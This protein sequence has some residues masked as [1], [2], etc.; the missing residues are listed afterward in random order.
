MV[1]AYTKGLINTHED[2][3]VFELDPF[4]QLRRFLI[5]GSLNGSFYA[6]P[7]D[8]TKLNLTRVQ[9]ALTL[10]GK[11]AIDMIADVSDKGLAQSNDPALA[12]LAL[13]LTHDDVNVRRYAVQ[14]FDKIVR[15]GTHM[16]HFLTFVQA[17]KK[18]W[19]STLRQA[20]SNW[21]TGKADMALVNQITKYQQR[22]GWSQADA[23]R[24]A[25]PKPKNSTQEAILGYAIDK[26]RDLTLASAEVQDYLSGIKMMQETESI[27][28]IISLIGQY[29][30]P[31]EVLPTWAL[32]DPRVWEA[33]LPHMG[34]QAMMR[35]LG[36]MASNGFL[37]KG[38]QAEKDIVAAIEDTQK[39]RKSRVHPLDVLKAKYVYE[40]G[41]GVRGSKTWTATPQ[42]V[43]ALD[44]AF[45][46]SFDNVTPTGKRGMIALDVSASMTW[47]NIGNVPN[48]TPR[49]ASA[50]MALVTVRTEQDTTVTAFS[51]GITELPWFHQKATLDSVIYKLDRIPP[52]GTDCGLPMRYAKNNYR[53][54][55]YFIVYTDSDTYGKPKND[56]DNYR[57][58]QVSDARFICVGMVSNNFTLSDP[59][60]PLSMDVVGF[61]SSAPAIMSEFIR[62]GI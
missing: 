44:D 12:A 51:S 3:T 36:V 17:S 56:L 49:I 7:Q 31:R 45:Y 5:L 2:G 15:T 23:I 39:L 19:R 6:S 40:A 59:N 10:D 20:V 37:T 47:S 26:D 35:N 61:D 24:L 60:D 11:K 13:A 34:M 25:H 53:D 43:M 58:V 46:G 21:Y 28:V 30:Y 8:L 29:K 50:A 32:N 22:D 27:E 14:K 18:G 48:F 4:G 33:M 9:E 41:H 16:F 55:D 62:G 52:A 42:V 54:Y 57:A 1:A 38:S